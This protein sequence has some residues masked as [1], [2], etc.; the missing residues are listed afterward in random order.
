MICGWMRNIGIMTLRT[1]YALRSHIS[2]PKRRHGS[3]RHGL[4]IK[5]GLRSPR[6]RS[7]EVTAARLVCDAHRIRDIAV[8][9][10]A[11]DV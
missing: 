8:W 10:V 1:R 4:L 3:H 6:R 2:L 7:Y 9:S 5:I 11:A